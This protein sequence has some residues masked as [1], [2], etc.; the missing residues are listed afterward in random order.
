MF[1][2]RPAIRRALYGDDDY[3]S[4]PERVAAIKVLEEWG[5]D[6]SLFTPQSLDEVTLSIVEQSDVRGDNEPT[7]K[8]RNLFRGS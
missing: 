1:T 3:A 5:F 4:S 6:F 7:L 8:Q 2:K